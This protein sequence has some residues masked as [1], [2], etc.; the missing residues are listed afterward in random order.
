MLAKKLLASTFTAVIFMVPHAARAYDTFGTVDAGYSSTYSEASEW[1]YNG[2]SDYSASSYY[3][4]PSTSTSTYYDYSHSH[5]SS[6]HHGGEQ[7]GGV[8]GLLVLAI[9][10]IGTVMDRFTEYKQAAEQRLYEEYRLWEK[11]AA[12]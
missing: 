6:S 1:S 4:S 10:V 12:I 11:R 9:I 2:D 3:E 8:I 7:D 5:S